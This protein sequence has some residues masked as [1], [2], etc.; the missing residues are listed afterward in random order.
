MAYDPNDDNLTALIPPP[1]A[2]RER[3]SRLLGEVHILRALLKV[4]EQ[5]ERQ[6]SR[7][8]AEVDHAD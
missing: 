4:S 5:K 1:L 7:S 8:D 3:I 2:V 6:E